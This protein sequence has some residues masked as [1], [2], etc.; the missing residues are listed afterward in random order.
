[1]TVDNPCPSVRNYVSDRVFEGKRRLSPETSAHIARLAKNAVSGK[2][3]AE[4]S[5]KLY[6]KIMA[7][8]GR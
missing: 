3:T 1:M 5:L 7:E 2:A 8:L 4:D 6:P